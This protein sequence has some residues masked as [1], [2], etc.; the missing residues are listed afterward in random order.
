MAGL[1]FVGLPTAMGTDN[2]GDVKRVLAHELGH[3][4]EQLHT[5][6][7]GPPN[8]DPGYPY[9][10]GIGV[11]GF[12]VAALDLKPPSTSDIMG[13]CS[14][15][16]ISD[17]IYKRVMNYRQAT[18]ASAQVASAARQPALLVWGRIVNGQAVLEPAFRIVTRPR[19]PDRP[20]PYS[21]E[22]IANDGSSLFSLS[23]EAA[24]VADDPRGS[25]H[26][27][28]AVP[29]DQARADR[30]ADLRL[31]GP[32]GVAS[33]ASLSVARLRKGAALDSIIVRRDA[34]G[35][36]LTWNPSARPM[37]IVRDPDTGEVLSFARGGKGRV[38]TSKERLDLMESDGVQSRARR[39]AVTR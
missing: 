5:P 12:D 26:F 30:L 8:V 29:L 15:P 3:T 21:V 16:W 23:F 34:D 10:T 24:E 27:A 17:Y 18:T 25:R 6:C 4:W 2:P 7:A 37:I 1:G 13:Y 9:G 20:G 28:F 38:K 14:G 11:Y 33:A 36:A 39:I 32:G 22:G 19:L 35:V 31:S